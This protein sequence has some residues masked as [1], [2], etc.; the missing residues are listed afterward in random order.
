M[1]QQF[2]RNE[3]K[4]KKFLENQENIESKR[5]VMLVEN[6]CHLV[7]KNAL[8]YVLAR[9]GK[10]VQIPKIT[11]EEYSAGNGKNTVDFLKQ[12]QTKYEGSRLLMLWDGAS[13]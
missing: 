2:L 6:E 9:K 4:L 11:I 10:S 5:L 13:Y 1:R 8:G 7:W 3:K 12:L